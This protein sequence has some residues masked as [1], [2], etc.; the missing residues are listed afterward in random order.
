MH[1]NFLLVK[2]LYT[3]SMEDK[4]KKSL[5]E[6]IV[7]TEPMSVEDKALIAEI[8]NNYAKLTKLDTYQF[9][10]DF[11]KLFINKYEKWPGLFSKDVIASHLL[12]IAAMR[13]SK[14]LRNDEVARLEIV[15]KWFNEIRK[16]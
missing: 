2:I 6:Q 5:G 13:D 4:P 9:K 16:S 11:Q 8:I 12:A 1:E 14:Q 3:T 7:E 15:E 10:L